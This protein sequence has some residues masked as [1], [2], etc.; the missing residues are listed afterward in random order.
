MVYLSDVSTTPSD[1]TTTDNWGVDPC[2]FAQWGK[3]KFEIRNNYLDQDEQERRIKE[4]DARNLRKDEA[5]RIIEHLINQ[6]DYE[7]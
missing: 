4:L 2:T 1:T 6:E 3:I 7:N 5:S